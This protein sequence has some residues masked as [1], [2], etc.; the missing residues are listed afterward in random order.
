[1]Q[2][3]NE[4]RP[5]GTWNEAI[6]AD[7]VVLDFDGRH[8]RRL[9]MTGEAGLVFLLDLPRAVVLRDGDGLVLRDGRIVRVTAAPEPLVEIAAPDVAALVRIAWHL[10]NRHLPTQLREDRLRIRHDHVIIDMVRGLGGITTEIEAPFDP[11]G[12]AFN[13]SVAHGHGHSHGSDHEHLHRHD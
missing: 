4:V 1:M 8:R 12:G 6:T 7:T 3:C 13:V 9:A 5:A 2:T 10:G 11:E